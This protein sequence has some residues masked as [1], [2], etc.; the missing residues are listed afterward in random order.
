MLKLDKDEAMQC[1]HCNTT[2]D[3]PA[4]EHTYQLSEGWDD[5]LTGTCDDC[6]GYFYAYNED[7]FVIVELA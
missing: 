6:L 7:G 3:E 1:P 2:L 5:G 4:R